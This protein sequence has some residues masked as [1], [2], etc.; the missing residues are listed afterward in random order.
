MYFLLDLDTIKQLRRFR[1]AQFFAA[2]EFVKVFNEMRESLENYAKKSGA[3]PAE[4]NKRNQMLASIA[5]YANK[6]EQLHELIEA[7]LED[8]ILT[9]GACESKH[10]ENIAFSLLDYIT[11]QSE[12]SV[13]QK[14]IER[15]R[16]ALNAFIHISQA[17]D[18]LKYLAST[19]PDSKFIAIDG[20]IG[21]L[22][23]PDTSAV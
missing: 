2:G 7:I 22:T 23:K 13:A 12:Q 21:H 10:I 9:Y 20:N 17:I 18:C 11:K 1:S 6:T 8:S 4:V 16:V 14:N 15:T 19:L 3:D 5:E